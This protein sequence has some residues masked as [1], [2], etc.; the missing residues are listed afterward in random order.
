MPIQH[1][2]YMKPYASMVADLLHDMDGGNSNRP[3]QVVYEVN[4]PNLTV[5]EEADVKR[6]VDEIERR[7]KLAERSR[8]LLAFS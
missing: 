2:R 1:R 5:R 6:I 4:M 3:S 7:R 8:G